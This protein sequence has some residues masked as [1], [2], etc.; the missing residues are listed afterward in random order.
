MILQ[1]LTAHELCLAISGICNVFWFAESTACVLVLR[2][3]L[4]GG[5]EMSASVSVMS[6]R[7]RLEFNPAPPAYATSCKYMVLVKPEECETIQDLEILIIRKFGYPRGTVISLSV[8]GFCLPAIES[9]HLLSRDDIVQVSIAEEGHDAGKRRR[10]K[11][12]HCKNASHSKNQGIKREPLALSDTEGRSDNTCLPNSTTDTTSKKVK[13]IKRKHRSH[14]PANTENPVD[15]NLCEV[16]NIKKEKK[17]RLEDMKSPELCKRQKIQTPPTAEVQSGSLKNGITKYQLDFKKSPQQH[18]KQKVK[19]ITKLNEQYSE[20]SNAE[21]ASNLSERHLFQ[22]DSE[23]QNVKLALEK[24]SKKHD[25]NELSSAPAG[26]SP[27]VSTPNK[28]CNNAQATG[29]KTNNN[30][31]KQKRKSPATGKDMNGNKSHIKFDSSSS[32]AEEESDEEQGKRKDSLDSWLDSAKASINHTKQTWSARNFKDPGISTNVSS[33]YTNPVTPKQT[34]LESQSLANFQMDKKLE[35]N[36]DNMLPSTW[37][38]RVGDVIA[39]KVLE[40]AL[41]YTPVVSEYM[42]AKIQQVMS[43]ALS[44]TGVNSIQVELLTPK[45][46]IKREGGRYEMDLEEE[47][48]DELNDTTAVLEWKTLLQTK[49]VN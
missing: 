46:I 40:M 14:S 21:M 41:D 9:I 7:I 4:L 6:F 19:S 31:Q 42:E 37:P 17:R 32:S 49:L 33:V 28:L 23:Q 12:R 13:L 24:P 3:P 47:S 36:Y 45:T 48:D 38:P 34:P 1:C 44:P 15:V 43:E 26:P 39:Y 29:N 2:K 10:K 22:D 16:V 8:D 18:Q 30:R 27:V 11:I 20:R 35:K 5:T 25:S